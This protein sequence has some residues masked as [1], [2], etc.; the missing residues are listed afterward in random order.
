MRKLIERAGRRYGRLL[1]TTREPNDAR[2]NTRW[3]YLCDCGT[4]G[5][6]KG[7]ALD[8]GNTKSC[9]CLRKDGQSHVNH[10][11]SH[12]GRMTATYRTWLALRQ[13][14]SNPKDASYPNY[15]GRGIQVCN[16]WRES[17]ENFLAD[18]GEKPA[19]LS[20]ERQ[21]NEGHYTPDNCVW[22]DR[23]TQNKNR[24]GLR[25]YHVDG[26]TFGLVALS[27]HWNLNQHQTRR[28]VAVESVPFTTLGEEKEPHGQ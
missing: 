3:R 8:G 18:M 4:V 6:L 22:A 27:R 21:D 16:R 20:I 13:R 28:R 23:H 19:G 1:I 24:R 11:H 9:G 12:R 14:V 25:Q 17:F 26:Q 2:G 7:S 10:G 15:G 5:S